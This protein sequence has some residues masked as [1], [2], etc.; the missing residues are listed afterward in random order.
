MAMTR[1]DYKYVHNTLGGITNKIDD[2][3]L[4]IGSKVNNLL[5]ELSDENI[6]NANYPEYYGEKKSGQWECETEEV[7]ISSVQ[8]VEKIQNISV[9]KGFTTNIDSNTYYMGTTDIII[10]DS[11][12]I[13]LI[14]TN[15]DTSLFL[16]KATI[17]K[18]DNKYHC[19]FYGSSLPV[20]AT[21]SYK[22]EN[23]IENT[24][25]VVKNTTIQNGLLT[26]NIILKPNKSY[27]LQVLNVVEPYNSLP[28]NIIE[29]KNNNPTKYN[30]KQYLFFHTGDFSEKDYSF[31]LYING[32]SFGYKIYNKLEDNTVAQARSFF[33]PVKA[34][35][36]LFESD[37]PWIVN[38]KGIIVGLSET[39]LQVPINSSS[40]P[41]NSILSTAEIK[42]IFSKKPKLQIEGDNLVIPLPDAVPI[43][44][45]SEYSWPYQDL[46]VATH[47]NN[48]QPKIMKRL[49]LLVYRNFLTS[50]IRDYN[51]RTYSTQY[52]LLQTLEKTKY[53]PHDETINAKTKYSIDIDQLSLEYSSSNQNAL[54]TK[55][56]IPSI[57]E[58]KISREETLYRYY[59]TIN[60]N[61]LSLLGYNYT[62]TNLKQINQ[63]EKYKYTSVSFAWGLW[64]SG[65]SFTRLSD[66]SDPLIINRNSNKIEFILN[67]ETNKYEYK[68]TLQNG[69]SLK[70]Q[71][72]TNYYSKPAIYLTNEKTSQ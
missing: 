36:Y 43:S 19:T 16:P 14:I 3:T 45:T 47:Q 50:E 35:V 25:T 41:V 65:N 72:S 52:G 51:N 22:I 32:L 34:K 38:E 69:Y 21:I 37:M 64:N 54:V 26:N 11:N 28:E 12:P 48:P 49:R 58:T 15:N 57:G 29:N 46:W 56:V 4:K 30:F 60:L 20:T 66:F 9:D 44:D 68:I 63:D 31:K 61:I 71:T 53:N 1:E 70:N 62:Y 6:Y 42:K 59:S 67:T 33:A 23:T 13:D 18:Q 8:M 5:L 7:S 24:I 17:E 27:V 39:Y 2:G 10:L 40:D 55:I